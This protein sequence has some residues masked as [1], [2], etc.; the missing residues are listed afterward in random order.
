MHV[1]DTP[2]SVSL[3]CAFGMHPCTKT[4][5]KLWKCCV[6]L[7]LLRTS[8]GLCKG[9][10]SNVLCYLILIATEPMYI[11][12]RAVHTH[13]RDYSCVL[14]CRGVAVLF[15]RAHSAVIG[16]LKGG[17]GRGGEGRRGVGV[18]IRS[19]LSSATMPV[20]WPYPSTMCGVNTSHVRLCT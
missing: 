14:L 16:M 20:V 9:M 2:A 10:S 11:H 19:Y 4:Y 12:R 8:R 17:G 18:T 3:C 7:R 13:R 6:C 1:V 15:I 5:V